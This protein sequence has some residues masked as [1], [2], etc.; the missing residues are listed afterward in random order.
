[1]T[2]HSLFDDGHFAHGGGNSHARRFDNES[3]LLL[4]L[5]LQLGG[6]FLARRL[7][8]LLLAGICGG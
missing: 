2:E 5:P 3:A 6:R 4:L 8:L 1:M 7:A